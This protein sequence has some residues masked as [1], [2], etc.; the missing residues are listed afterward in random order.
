MTAD[1]AYCDICGLDL[2]S[3]FFRVE[4][5]DICWTCKDMSENTGGLICLQCRLHI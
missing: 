5:Q 1:E 3:Q 4:G 2:G